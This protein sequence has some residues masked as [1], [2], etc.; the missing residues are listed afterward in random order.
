MIG[1]E[2]KERDLHKYKTRNINH[3]TK[4]KQGEAVVTNKIENDKKRN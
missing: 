3:T 1:P 4:R 2:Q